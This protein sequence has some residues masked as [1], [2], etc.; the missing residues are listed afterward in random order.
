MQ[1]SCH[2]SKILHKIFAHGSGESSG[3]KHDHDYL[4][5]KLKVSTFRG[6]E[7]KHFSVGTGEGRKEVQ[8]VQSDWESPKKKSATEVLPGKRSCWGR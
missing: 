4:M 6:K 8:F 7:G 2:G 3:S 1:Q 5:R